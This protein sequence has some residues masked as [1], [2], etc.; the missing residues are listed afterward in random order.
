MASLGASM[1]TGVNRHGV[2]LMVRVDTWCHHS[3]SHGRPKELAFEEHCHLSTQ[4]ISWCF[5]PPPARH[6]W[7]SCICP[8]SRGFLG[9]SCAKH[10]SRSQD[11]TVRL[12]KEE[13][14]NRK[15][16]RRKL[17]GKESGQVT[18]VSFIRRGQQISF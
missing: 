14:G 5:Q 12:W 16:L 4:R 17:N 2:L 10:W 1:P 6:L 11:T 13:V 15:M 7:T 3:D 9:D 8:P 18:G